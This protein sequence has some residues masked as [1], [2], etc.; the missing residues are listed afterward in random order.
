MKLEANEGGNAPQKRTREHIPITALGQK[1]SLNAQLVLS[2]PALKISCQG[3]FSRRK[4]WRHAQYQ[5]IQ[6]VFYGAARQICR[7]AFSSARAA[8]LKKLHNF[9]RLPVGAFPSRPSE[10][11]LN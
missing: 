9:H 2:L 5:K 7:R 10:F 11:R 1:P 3:R 4:S 8:A 6:L